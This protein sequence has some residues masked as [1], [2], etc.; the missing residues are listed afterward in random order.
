M[1]VFNEKNPLIATALVKRL[2]FL[3]S[4]FPNQRLSYFYLFGGGGGKRTGSWWWTTCTWFS[5]RIAALHSSLKIIFAKKYLLSLNGGEGG[6][7]DFRLTCTWTSNLN[8]YF[9]P[10]NFMQTFFLFLENQ[11]IWFMYYLLKRFSLCP[12][13]NVT[14]MTICV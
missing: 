5:E 1:H 10:I 2:F 9:F 3:F 11:L 12:S 7:V 6:F 8:S 13:Q 4:V 14:V